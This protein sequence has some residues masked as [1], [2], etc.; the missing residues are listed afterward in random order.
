MPESV[1]VRPA[2]PGDVEALLRVKARS[3]RE[4]YG[5]LLPS[6]YLDAVEARI[7]EDVPAWTALIGSDRDLWVADDGGRLL[8]VA[9]A[10]PRR[11]AAETGRTGADDAAASPADLPEV[12]LMV[13]YVLAEA[14]GTGLGARLLDAVVGDR[15]A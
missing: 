10:G 7:P 1:T 6:A 4:A 9:L 11:S 13:L 5:A 8:G 2:A 12:E 3:W 14:Y 15:P